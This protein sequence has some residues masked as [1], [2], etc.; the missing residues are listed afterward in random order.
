MS[1]KS[2]NEGDL[3]K[4][5]IKGLR[6][7]NFGSYDILYQVTWEGLSGLNRHLAHTGMK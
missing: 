3:G 4:V 5:V 7:R 2:E 6:V 1:G